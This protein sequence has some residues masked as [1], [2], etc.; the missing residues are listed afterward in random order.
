[1]RYEA[2]HNEERGWYVVSDEGH[3]AH[4]PDPDTHHLRAAIFEREADA[5]RCAQELSRLGTLS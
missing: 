1:M 5:E 4:V 3:L 2:R